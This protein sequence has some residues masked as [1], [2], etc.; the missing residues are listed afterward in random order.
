M[1]LINVS[2][3]EVFSEHRNIVR[4]RAGRAARREGGRTARRL[5]ADCRPTGD[6]VPLCRIV[7]ADSLAEEVCS[8]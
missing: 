7:G 3:R 4:W 6:S 8:D 5:G 1:F 2:S